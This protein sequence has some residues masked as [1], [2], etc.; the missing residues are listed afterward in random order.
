MTINHRGTLFE[1]GI[2]KKEKKEKK[3]STRVVLFAQKS[4]GF[5]EYYFSPNMTHFKNPRGLQP[6]HPTPPA[7]VR[8]WFQCILY[9][10]NICFTTN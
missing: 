7:L 9:T 10:C 3:G 6:P 4:S 8:L 1:A 2:Q 5:V